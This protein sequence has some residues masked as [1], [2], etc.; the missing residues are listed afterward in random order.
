MVGLKANGDP[1]CV[2]PVKEGYKPSTA[3]RLNQNLKK[4]GFDAD[5][6][7]ARIDAIMAKYKKPEPIKPEEKKDVKENLAADFAAFA[8]AR[9]GK[10]APSAEDRKKATHKL[11]KHRAKTTP[12]SVPPVHDTSMSS[13]SAYYASKKPGQYTGD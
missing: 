8:K 2:G 3:E 1:N 10:V 12:Q 7:R 4:A 5:A 6:S 13:P 9:G 11:I